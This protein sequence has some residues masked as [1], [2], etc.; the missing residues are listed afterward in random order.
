MA[1][2]LI[3]SS[4]NLGLGLGAYLHQG[5]SFSEMP[6]VIAAIF[7]ILLVGICIELLAFRPLERAVLRARGLTGA[8][9]RE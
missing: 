9:T 1:A 7:L 4:P 5:S 6:M 3:A 2:E 8:L